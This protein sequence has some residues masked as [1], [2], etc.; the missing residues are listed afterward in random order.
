MLVTRSLVEQRLQ[1]CR[2]DMATCNQWT[3]SP[4]WLP[5]CGLRQKWREIC[6]KDQSHEQP[7]WLPT[8]LIDLG[9][10]KDQYVKLVD[11]RSTPTRGPYATLSHRWADAAVVQT[12]S[13]NLEQFLHAIPVTQDAFTAARSYLGVRYIW[14]VSLC[15]IQDDP[16][17][18][19]LSQ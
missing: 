6:T 1:S 7:A 8:R 18:G 12:T 4:S 2:E 11:T 10:S 13:S 19:E 16:K 17:I 14:I 15:I 9:P 5:I 3:G